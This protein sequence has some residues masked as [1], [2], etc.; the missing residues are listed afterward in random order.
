M[1]FSWCRNYLHTV[2]SVEIVF[3]QLDIM[4]E[5]LHTPY[6]KDYTDNAFRGAVAS[7]CFLSVFIVIGLVN[8]FR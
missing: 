8:K 6:Y 1:R 7:A 3:H 5:A 2:K 4:E